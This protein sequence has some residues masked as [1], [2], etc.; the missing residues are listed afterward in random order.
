[1][2][3]HHKLNDIEHAGSRLIPQ[4]LHLVATLQES[5][6]SSLLFG[7][8][9]LT[10]PLW[11]RVGLLSYLHANPSA[12]PTWR[13]DWQGSKR[14]KLKELLGSLQFGLGALGDREIV[15][16]LHAVIHGNADSGEWVN[17]VSRDDGTAG[18]SPGP[19]PDSPTHAD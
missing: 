18:F 12:L 9:V 11:E 16:I 17:L 8:L 10:R 6:H 1:Y 13:N 19:M 15:N 4:A 2:T 3:R 5:V 7:G 14:P